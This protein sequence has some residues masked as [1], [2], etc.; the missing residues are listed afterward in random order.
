VVIALVAVTAAGRAGA[1]RERGARARVFMPA[2][3]VWMLGH[4]HCALAAPAMCACCRGS[5]SGGLVVVLL[6]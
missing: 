4:A 2:V 6:C 5:E 3:V 1:L